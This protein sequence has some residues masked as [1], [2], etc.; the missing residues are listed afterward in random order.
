MLRPRLRT[1]GNLLENALL[2]SMQVLVSWMHQRFMWHTGPLM[3]RSSHIVV[4]ENLQVPF[5]GY[6]PPHAMPVLSRFPATYE[7]HNRFCAF[8]LRTFHL[9]YSISELRRRYDDTTR[10]KPAK[11]R[12]RKNPPT[13]HKLVCVPIRVV[14]LRDLKSLCVFSTS[15]C[16]HS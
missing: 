12:T 10:S 15:T 14:Q 9:N 7:R 16:K 5:I 13:H 3:E 11:C 6:S 8:Q 1:D 2:V 4:Y